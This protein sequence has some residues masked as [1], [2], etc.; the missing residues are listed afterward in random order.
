MAMLRFWTTVSQKK[1][2][3][4]C[5]ALSFFSRAICM[6]PMTLGIWVLACMPVSLSSCCNRGCNNN[7]CEK[8]SASSRY[9]GFPT[10]KGQGQSYQECKKE[11]L[12]FFH[13][14]L[15]FVVSTRQT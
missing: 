4:S 10:A 2:L 14:C 11:Y 13:E 8:R 5:Q 3:A 1:R 6:K 12:V 15:E 9:F 7:W